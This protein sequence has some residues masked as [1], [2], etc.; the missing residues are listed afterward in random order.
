MTKP[1]NISECS[2]ADADEDGSLINNYRS[3]WHMGYFQIVERLNIADTR[4]QL[5]EKILEK[6]QSLE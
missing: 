3:T 2:C 6:T 4:L 5:M 1:L